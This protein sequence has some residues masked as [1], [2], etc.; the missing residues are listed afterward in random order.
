M[1]KLRFKQRKPDVDTDNPQPE[2]PNFLRRFLA[3]LKQGRLLS[4]VKGRI[5]P[6]VIRVGQSAM[7]HAWLKQMALAGL[8]YA[9][10]LKLRLHRILWSEVNLS[11]RAFG[12]YA[13]LKAAI[14]RQAL[15]KTEKQAESSV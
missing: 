1:N 13:E 6:M 10:G 15:E 3:V 14:E 7:K 2:K 5:K 8:N 9:P 11:P 4:V 12:I